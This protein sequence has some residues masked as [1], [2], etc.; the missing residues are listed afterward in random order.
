M[1][2]FRKKIP[3]YFKPL[4]YYFQVNLSASWLWIGGRETCTKSGMNNIQLRAPTSFSSAT[5]L[6]VNSSA[7]LS[8]RTASID[9]L[10]L[11][12]ILC[13]GELREKFLFRMNDYLILDP[14]LG[15]SVPRQLYL[16]PSCL[17]AQR[18]KWYY[19]TWRQRWVPLGYGNSRQQQHL[20]GDSD[21]DTLLR[22]SITG[23]E[24]VK[25]LNGTGKI[26]LL[27]LD[28]SAGVSETLSNPCE[29][30]GCSH[31]SVL[32]GSDSF[33]CLCPQGWRLESDQMSCAQDM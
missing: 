19:S 11:L 9:S 2:L 8:R 20:L 30:Q 22:S 18:W 1:I 25:V 5:R 33:R 24:V 6:L 26:N 27:T 32:S 4:C 7:R 12:W 14:R 13:E 23:H 3:S 29:G 17:S 10:P 16:P 21:Q 15:S 31:I 28:Y